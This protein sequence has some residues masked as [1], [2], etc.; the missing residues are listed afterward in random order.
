M[1]EA[2]A[3]VTLR[4][5]RRP[6]ADVLRAYRV[7]IDDAEVGEIRRGQTVR[8]DVAPGAHK[9][10]LEI[11]WCTSHTVAL[12][13]APGQEAHLECKARP[14]M[15]GWS[16]AAPSGYI[17]LEVVGPGEAVFT[18]PPPPPPPDL[19][20]G[21]PTD[22]ELHE[23]WEA[24]AAGSAHVTELRRALQA[25]SDDAERERL[26][27]TVDEVIPEYRRLADEYKRLKAQRPDWKSPAPAPPLP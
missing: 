16:A 22:D 15:G 11:D 14:P 10:H 23:A 7:L 3:R 4:R 5:L 20:P 19:P 6:V 1:P 21:A 2:T 13:L 18:P 24:R 9:V 26:K 12:A 8:Y 17:S 25:A 27:R